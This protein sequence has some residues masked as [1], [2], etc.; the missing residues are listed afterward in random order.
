MRGAVPRRLGNSGKVSRTT[1]T[2]R[3]TCPTMMGIKTR[4]SSPSTETLDLA[5]S[6]GSPGRSGAPEPLR[7][8]RFSESQPQ[9]SRA[10]CGRA[11]MWAR[12]RGNR[13]LTIK[14]GSR[15]QVMAQV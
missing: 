14:A 13:R 9:P 15:I 11:M 10:D 3:L 5:R 7:S 2:G 6:D 1:V 8:R 12:F 4:T